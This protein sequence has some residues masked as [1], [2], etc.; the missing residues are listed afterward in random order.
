MTVEHAVPQWIVKLLPKLHP[1][2]TSSFVRMAS[3]TE[4]IEFTTK[5][6]QA[7]TRTVC[8]GCNSGWM[9]ELEKQAQPLIEP[10][11][12]GE[13]TTLRG[14]PDRTTV[15]A[16]IFKTTLVWY[17]CH[18]NPERP[19]PVAHY[20]HLHEHHEPPAEVQIWIGRYGLTREESAEFR[21]TLQRLPVVGLHSGHW[22]RHLELDEG[23]GA[24]LYGYTAAFN[25]AVLAA[26]VFGNDDIGSGLHVHKS[27][28]GGD[29]SFDGLLIPIWPPDTIDWP[30]SG[31]VTRAQLDAIARGQDV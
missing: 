2:A 5:G 10:M 14:R 22:R 29:F 27:G 19:L 25:I 16:W 30:P 23:Q 13:T 15:A 24:D 12:R 28:A 4:S 3:D 21:R 9:S 6:V 18:P 20:R 31:R 17:L 7:R 1:G 11:L 8:S 26:H